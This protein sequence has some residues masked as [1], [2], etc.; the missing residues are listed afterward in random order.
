MTTGTDSVARRLADP[1]TR[2]DAIEALERHRGPHDTALA[3]TLTDLMALDAAEMPHPLFQRVGL[4]RAR[5]C[6]ETPPDD[7]VALYKSMFG[8]GRREAEAKSPSNVVAAAV[9]KGAA[10]LTREDALSIAC[11]NA[12]DGPMYARD[13]SLHA[14]SAEFPSVAPPFISK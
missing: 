5:L 12:I 9:A 1:A 2:V 11:A 10:A 8:E 13:L 3:P 7:R 6:D 14:F 4:L